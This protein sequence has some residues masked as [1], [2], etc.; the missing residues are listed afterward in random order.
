MINNF[1]FFSVK[2]I[3]LDVFFKKG[4]NQHTTIQR[5]SHKKGTHGKH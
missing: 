2:Y 3:H 1:H 4:I 5:Q